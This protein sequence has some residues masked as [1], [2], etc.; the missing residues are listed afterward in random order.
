MVKQQEND[1]N[2][3]EN[4]SDV[5]DLSDEGLLEDIQALPPEQRDVVAKCIQQV[6]ISSWKVMSMFYPVL[7]IEF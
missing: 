2:D 6:K 7:L 5:H 1:L 4:L 3:V